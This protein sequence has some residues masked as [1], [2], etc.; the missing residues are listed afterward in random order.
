MDSNLTAFRRVEKYFK[1][2]H[3]SGPEALKQ[4]RKQSKLLA[5]LGFGG[6]AVRNEDYPVLRGQGVINLS[7]TG[8]RD[9]VRDAGWEVE[10]DSFGGREYEEIEVEKTDDYGDV[11]P[12]KVKGYIIGDGEYFQ[13]L[14]KKDAH[15][16]LLGLIYIPQYLSPAAQLRLAQSSLAEYTN[17]PNPLN[18]S[19][20]YVLLP[21]LS[22]FDKYLHDPDHLVDSKASASSTPVSG[23]FPDS[24]RSCTNSA[25]S[26]TRSRP[27]TPQRELI[28]NRPA[29]EEGY[30][31]L[32]EKVA[33]WKGDEP[34]YKLRSK[35]VGSLME[36]ELR[37]ANLGW[38]YNVSLLPEAEA[39]SM[40]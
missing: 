38:V 16:I 31:A 21:H 29:H 3:P 36:R 19:T 34:S 8:T 18:L 28:S 20:H 6:E 25:N 39:W 27:S 15:I 22:L 17:P 10:E 1:S 13:T 14:T 2:R 35:P 32:K 24:T 9:E 5:A 33:Q 26:S 23:T 40:C 7:R 11:S 4:K 30:E 37:W 12:S